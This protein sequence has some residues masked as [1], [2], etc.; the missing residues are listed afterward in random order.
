MH[1]HMRRPASRLS[2]TD[3]RTSRVEIRLLGRFD[4]SV[5]GAPTPEHG[6]RRRT[7]AALVKVLALAPG[8]RLHREQVI[9]MLWA[10][11]LPADAA[12]K[13]H[14]AAHY[15]RK[16]AGRHDAVVLR[17][18]IVQLFPTA[19]LIVDA[20][21]FDELS[22]EAITSRD[23][24]AARTAIEHYPGE[25]L[26]DDRYEEWA[27]DRRELLRLRHVNLLR[28]TGQWLEVSELDPSDERAHVELMRGHVA[29]GDPGAAL[30]HYARLERV[31]DRDLGVPPGPA[32][33]AIRDDLEISST[34]P[35]AVQDRDEQRSVERVE[36]LESLV[37]ELA[38][39]T[40]RQT[41]LLHTLARVAPCGPSLA[42][43]PS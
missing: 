13:L 40:R 14:K 1:R 21:L 4:V 37:V 30:L 24:I 43:A 20:V 5:D 26:P 15:A 41:I 2:P 7:A 8:H 10:D 19:E 27:G 22:R 6:W 29:N 16:A 35:V 18:D 9:D 39:L 31:L 17:N 36:S 28:L 32:A 23:P 3:A 38:E 11:E 25:L 33:R 12:P 42:G 34:E